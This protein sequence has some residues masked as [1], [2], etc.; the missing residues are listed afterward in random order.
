MIHFARRHE[1][2]PYAQV[3]VGSPWESVL[4]QAGWSVNLA[5]PKG[6]ESAVLSAPL[7]ADGCGATVYDNPPPGWLEVA[8]RGP[9]SENQ[10][11]ILTGGPK[12][13][14]ASIACGGEIAGVARGCVV[15]TWLHIAVLE[16][17][18]EYRRRGLGRQ[19]LSDLDTWAAQEGAT[20]RVLQVSVDNEV[21]LGIYQDLGYAESHRYRYWAP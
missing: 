3:V 15:G 17:R 7:S 21:A 16:V 11:Q 5:H 13:G 19:L 20:D 1:I 14:F 10:R 2:R 9:V 6:A 18:Q 12:V 8:V 4:S